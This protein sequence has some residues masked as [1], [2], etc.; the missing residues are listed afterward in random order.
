M[1][2]PLSIASGVAGLI[3]LADVVLERT[4]KTIICCKNAGD[5]A[6][7]LTQEVQTLLGVLKGL[8]VLE[9]QVN[10]SS[11]FQTKIPADVRHQCQLTLERLRDKLS[12]ADPRGTTSKLKKIQRTLMWPLTCSETDQVLAEIERY[13][14]TFDLTVSIETLEAMFVSSK[15]Q[16]RLTEDIDKIKKQLYRVEITRERR[17]MLNFFGTFDSEPNHQMS[18]RLRLAG[19][20]LWLIT[21]PELQKWLSQCNSK[22]WLYGIPGA[23]KTVLA[24]MVIE[25]ALRT[26]SATEYSIGVAYYYCDYKKAK[27]RDLASILASLAGQL[28]R[29]NEECLQSLQKYFKPDIDPSLPQ[30]LPTEQ[31]LLM[32]ILEMAVKFDEIYIVIDGVDECHSAGDVADVLSQLVSSW[33]ANIKMCIL[34]R[35]ERGIGPF[36]DDFTHVSIAAQSSDLRLYVSTQIEE[37]MRKRTLRIHTA[38]LKDK[39]L[40]TLVTRADGM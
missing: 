26:A 4:Y 9:I 35:N 23:G 29:Q 25:E 30:S 13:K 8:H 38:G 14:S 37:R 3:T 32:L 40:E 2:D 15:E 21:G 28:A 6:R 12:D 16:K 36:L 31:Q 17:A 22:L 11:T 19:T 27:S 10:N 39:I 24:A 20:G 34:S 7:R 18:V 1:A 5:D 33:T